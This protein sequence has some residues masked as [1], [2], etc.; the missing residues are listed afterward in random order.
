M[1]ALLV[2]IWWQLLNSVVRN[3]LSFVVLSS[4][5]DFHADIAVEGFDRQFCPE[6][7]LANRYEKLCMNIGAFTFE[8]AMRLHLDM[9]D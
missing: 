4:G 6:H 1:V 7:R 3:L 5:R 9:D 8:V 2:V